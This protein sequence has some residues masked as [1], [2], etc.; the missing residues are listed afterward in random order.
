MIWPTIKW[1]A[2]VKQPELEADHLHESSI[3]VKYVWVE[4]YLPSYAFMA[5]SG[6][7]F[8]TGSDYS[9]FFFYCGASEPDSD[10]RFEPRTF[11]DMH[12]FC[13]LMLFSI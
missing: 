7:T 5:C 6:T 8:P 1:V 10:I 4:L 9:A 12:L 2:G 11:C 13:N 3:N